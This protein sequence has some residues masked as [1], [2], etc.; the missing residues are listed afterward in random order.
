MR[1]GLPLRVSVE[2]GRADPG[3]APD[4]S[5]QAER[6]AAWL[7]AEEIDAIRSSPL[8][9][10]T[11]T[12]APL[13]A[14]LGLP[15]A[16]D[17]GLSEFDRDATEYVP[18]EELKA[19]NDPRWFALT[20]GHYDV[21]DALVDPEEFRTRV[22]ATFEAIVADHPGGRVVCVA[23]AGVINAYAGHVLG[24]DRPLWF[25]PGYTSISRIAASRR[26]HRSVVSLNETAHLR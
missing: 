7:A 20:Q 12:A 15:V 8:R 10:A 9:R 21:V 14:R 26:G 18:V 4:G 6:L 17:D 5:A 3:L 16:E 25:A 13:A 23:H 1:H 11:E 22:V 2:S 24:I 19:E